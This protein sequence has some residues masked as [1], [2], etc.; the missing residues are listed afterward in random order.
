MPWSP[1]CAQSKYV[2]VLAAYPDVILMEG[3]AAFQAD[4]AVR[5]GEKSYRAQR[6]VIATGAQPRMVPFPGLEEVEPLNST[7]L[8]DLDQLPKSLIVLGGRAVALE[9]AQLMA[10]LGVEVQVLQRSARL[11]P[12]HEPEIGLAIQA[13]FEQENIGVLTGV[14]VERLARER[15]M[16]VVHA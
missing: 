2:K 4:G 5:V 12:D 16:R 13:Y 1:A 9:M 3:H 14:Q 11:V 6:Y 15:Q 10:R 7:T 8:M